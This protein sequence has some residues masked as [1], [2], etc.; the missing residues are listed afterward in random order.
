VVES[1]FEIDDAD[2]NNFALAGE[3]CLRSGEYDN[4][5][6][7]LGAGIEEHER[8]ILLYRLLGRL[9]GAADDS[10]AALEAFE[11]AL[12]L[13]WVY[14]YETGQLEFDKESAFLAAGLYLK[15]STNLTRAEELFRSLLATGDEL[16]RPA[17]LSGAGQAMIVQGKTE[18]GTKFLVDAASLLP[19]D[20]EERKI[21]EKMLANI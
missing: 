13:R 19:E 9:H 20:A 2:I 15:T 4:G 14:D 3:T 21:L 12:G 7:I 5:I 6:E 17:F 16:N 18:E 1:A 8:S 11:T 10:V